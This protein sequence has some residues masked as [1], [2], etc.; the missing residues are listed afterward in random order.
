MGQER[1]GPSYFF[2][3]LVLG[4]LN[5]LVWYYLPKG[6]YR[7]W[8]LFFVSARTNKRH[9]HHPCAPTPPPPIGSLVLQLLYLHSHQLKISQICLLTLSLCLQI[10]PAPSHLSNLPHVCSKLSRWHIHCGV[11]VTELS[12]NKQHTLSRICPWAANWSSGCLVLN[13]KP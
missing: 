3:S 2:I 1:L 13:P 4:P 9:H 6:I 7:D 5:R 12:T 10:R 11:E 8:L